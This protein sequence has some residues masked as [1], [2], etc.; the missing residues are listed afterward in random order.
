MFRN[1]V[2]FVCS[3]RSYTIFLCSDHMVINQSIEHRTLR[4]MHAPNDI[5]PTKCTDAGSDDEE[6]VRRLTA[7]DTVRIVMITGFE[8]FNVSL[9]KKVSV[10][11][12]AI[13]PRS[14]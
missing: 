7:S 6:M 1:K 11:I 3:G 10:K 2:L 8:S 13:T 9:Y 4:C 5:L 14:C 12:Y